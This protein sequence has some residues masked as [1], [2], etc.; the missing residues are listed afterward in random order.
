MSWKDSVCDICGDHAGHGQGIVF[1]ESMV[2]YHRG[3][4]C[5][6]K[7]ELARIDYSYSK[8]GKL[9]SPGKVRVLL[10]FKRKLKNDAPTT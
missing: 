2:F 8:R 5:E 9:N 10:G 6:K 3:S 4:E 1:A 7:H